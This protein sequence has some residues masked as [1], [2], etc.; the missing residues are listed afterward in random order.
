MALASSLIFSL[1]CHSLK[2]G[3]GL[4]G[5]LL[6]HEH[7]TEA[8][9][10][11]LSVLCITSFCPRNLH[12]C[13]VFEWDFYNSCHSS[14][15]ILHYLS[16][17]QETCRENCHKQTSTPEF[18]LQADVMSVL[19]LDDL[20]WLQRSDS[21]KLPGKSVVLNHTQPYFCK[22]CEYSKCNVLRL[23][24][25]VTNMSLCFSRNLPISECMVCSMGSNCNAAGL[26][27]CRNSLLPSIISFR[28]L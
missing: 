24:I 22:N 13:C 2:F 19:L 26:F 3:I 10:L 5:H 11:P 6:N 21:P 15:C 28:I 18:L 7:Q 25:H 16:S 8:K 27:C 17:V 14:H 9:C 4:K 23:Y 12:I 20:Y 1:S